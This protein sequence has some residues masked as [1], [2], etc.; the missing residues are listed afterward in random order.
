[1]A[2]KKDAKARASQ[3]NLTEKNKAKRAE[4]NN[5]KPEGTQNGSGVS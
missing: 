3:N 5:Q 4:K 2:G 1:M